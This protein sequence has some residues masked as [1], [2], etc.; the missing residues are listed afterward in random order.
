VSPSPEATAVGP[1]EEIL[2]KLRGVPAQ[3]NEREQ[4]TTLGMDASTGVMLDDTAAV[5]YESPYAVARGAMLVTAKD[6]ETLYRGVFNLQ[7]R[8]YWDNLSGN[9]AVWNTKPESLA[10]ARL[11]P[12]FI[13]KVTNPVRRAQN[14]FNSNPLLFVVVVFLTLGI[15]AFV[16]RALLKKREKKS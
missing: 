11:G 2:E 10:T 13:Y 1:I 14:Q 4:P 9:L 6:S 8:L 15:L 3:R 12:E 16:L 5:A 7:D